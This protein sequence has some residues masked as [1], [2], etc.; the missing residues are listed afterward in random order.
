MLC[1]YMSFGVSFIIIS[2]IFIKLSTCMPSE[3]THRFELV[4]G[5]GEQLQELLI[6]DL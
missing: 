1:V 3:C 5:E 6:I 4:H 2:F